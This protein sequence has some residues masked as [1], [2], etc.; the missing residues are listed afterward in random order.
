MKVGKK[1]ILTI[2]VVAVVLSMAYTWVVYPSEEDSLEFTG[3]VIGLSS[4]NQPKLDLSAQ[5]I[6]DSGLKLGSEFTIITVNDTY[7][8]A[9]MLESYLGIL[10]F[11]IFVNVEDDGLVSIGCVGML[12]N[13]DEG[14]EVK[15]V[16]T[17]ESQRYKN[18]PDY[19][20]QY[21]ND[22]H[23]FP[24][25]EDFANFYEVTGGNIAPGVLYRSFSSL[26]DPA[27]QARVPYVNQLADEYGI[28][29]L[30]ALSFSDASVQSAISKYSGYCID[31]CKDGKYVAPNMGY[32][33]FQQKE[34][35]IQTLESIIDNDGPYLVH[36]NV[37]RDRT[38]F[39]I[40]L[41]QALCGCSPEEMM[42]C[43]ARAFCNLYN[44]EPGSKEYFVIINGT[45][46]RNM[47]LIANYD[48]IDNIL[49]MDWSKIDVSKID[50]QKA[51]YQYCTDYLGL[52]SEQI[53]KLLE[54][55]TVMG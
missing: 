22:V 33:Y 14:S 13:A 51:A 54:R 35:T 50:T 41:L 30:V 24:S 40:L 32:L 34:K 4:Y 48:K 39:V 45:Y 21:S 8:G 17:G 15:L 16:H 23:D 10:M 38:G 3:E 6:F 31:L 20:V 2:A 19:N 44:I 49:H 52:S 12:I 37:G 55:L 7:T 26:S 53:E 18:T 47:Y 11:D 28:K 25:E 9:I 36:C 29:Y 43:E 46:D 27:K 5:E 42:E 1:E